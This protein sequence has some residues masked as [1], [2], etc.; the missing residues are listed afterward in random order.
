MSDD[1]TGTSTDGEWLEINGAHWPLFKRVLIYA[2][3]YEGIAN[4]QET[5]GVVRLIVPGE[6]EVEVR[7]NEF[8]TRKSDVMCAVALLEN[9]DNR[10]VV[11]REVRFFEGHEPLDKGYG[12]GMRWR[13]GRK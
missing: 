5:D 10:I 13:A 2:F 3:I 8:G 1:R 4:W 6:P 7:M 9:V 11:R 12:W